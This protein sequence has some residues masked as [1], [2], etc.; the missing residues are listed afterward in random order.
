MV[1]PGHGSGGGK[2]REF[3][4]F[5]R[6]E[7]HRVADQVGPGADGLERIREKIRSRPAHESPLAAAWLA[8]SGFLAGRVRRRPSGGGQHTVP[9]PGVTPAPREAQRTPKRPQGWRGAILRPAVAVGVAAFAV[10]LVLV[11]VPPVRQEIVQLTKHGASAVTGSG[12]ASA[13]G[14]GSHVRSSDGGV[15]QPSSVTSPTPVARSSPTTSQAAT[16][17]ASEAASPNATH[18]GSS[19]PSP[20]VTP[21][22]GVTPSPTNGRHRH[23][24]RRPRPGASV[25]PTSSHGTKIGRPGVG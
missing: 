11:A 18:G 13:Q 23:R 2:G 10:G 4:E 16:R 9:A 3:A 12:G 14:Q 8:V 7:L 5:V 20:S 6:R 19:S 25:S 1:I 15:S 21:S 22:P 24:R 17:T